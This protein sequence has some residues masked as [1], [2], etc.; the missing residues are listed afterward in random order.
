ALAAN[1]KGKG[2]FGVNKELQLQ[3]FAWDPATRA[4]RFRAVLFHDAINNF[5]PQ[6]TPS[7]QWMMTRRD[8]RYNVYM[9]RG[10]EPDLANWVSTLV[11]KRLDAF[12]GFIPDEPIWY[13]QD[14]SSLVSLYR[15]NNSTGRIFISTSPGE[16]Q[17]WTM[18]IKTNFPNATSKIYSL[19]TTSWC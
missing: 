15:D 5:A 18:P 1:F 13:P 9:L 3:A 14:D 17:P 7:G 12:P 6:R 4:W 19:K 2:A 11:M 10:G 16:A 8:T